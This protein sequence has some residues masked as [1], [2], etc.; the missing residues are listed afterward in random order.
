MSDY[1][2]PVEDMRFL[3]KHVLDFDGQVASLPGFEEIDADLAGD[4][5][6]EAGRFCADILAPLNLAGDG[7]GCTL[8]EGK[9]TTPAG[10]P[11]AYHKFVDDGWASLSGDPEYGGQG[12]PR[13][14][15]I[16][17]DEMVS[18]ANLSFGLFPGLTRGAA[19]ALA[20][21]G[22]DELKARWL[23]ELV[24]GQSCGA[25]ALTESNAGTDLGLLRASA[26]QAGDGSFRITG[27]KIFISSG[28]QDFG[29]NVA[30]L[31]LARLPGAAPGVKGISMFLVPKL[32]P[33]D[34]DGGAGTP[35]AMSVGALEEKMGIHAQPTCVMNY[36][37]A[38]GWLVGEAGRGLNA[39]FTMMNAERLFVGIQGLGIAEIA[40]Q[41]AAN[42][43]RERLQ[44]RSPDGSQAPA[45]IIV[46]ADVR[47]MLLQGRGFTEAARA[48]GIWTA[49]QMDIAARHPAAAEREK[50]QDLVLL[51]TPVIKA[52]FTDMGFETAV[53]SQQVFGGHGYI[54]E[55][56]MEQFV[57][58]ARITQ[59][60]E[61]TNGVQAMDLVGRKLSMGGGSVAASFFDRIAADLERSRQFPGASGLA[62]PVEEAL[63][64]LRRISADMALAS[65]DAT[66]LGAAATDVLRLFA[67]VSLGWMWVRMAAASEGHETP[68]AVRK[69]HVARFFAE[70]MLPQA[71]A[72]ARQIDAGPASIAGMDAQLF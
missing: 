45:P 49:M 40:Q 11:E 65:R 25:M 8:A 69:R 24:S 58:D 34:A 35:N 23:P 68:I 55:W 56:G 1:L 21:H 38:T 63:A 51:L 67:L 53:L 9:V 42:Y 4:V 2:P 17:L 32:L 72:L 41:H 43:A 22:S 6:E 60:Y 29:N 26:Q 70:R 61:G 13:T 64:L 48:L 5:L 57:R 59:I 16:M 33:D 18:A 28:D 30:H 62:A 36:D 20:H 50:A 15:Q 39:M 19:E 46:H 3:L 71:H 54:R 10:T 27:T 52:A 37:G 47:K 31:V 44:G 12:L 66:A 7:Q 14:V